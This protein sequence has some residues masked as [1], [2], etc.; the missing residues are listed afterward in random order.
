M[1]PATELLAIRDDAKQRL[2]ELRAVERV[3]APDQDDVAVLSELVIVRS[4]IAAA[5]RALAGT[6]AA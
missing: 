4:Q 5:E 3:L 6:E 2:A 1:M